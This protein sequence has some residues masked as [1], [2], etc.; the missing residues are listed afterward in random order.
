MPPILHERRG[1]IL[2]VALSAQCLHAALPLDQRPA[3]AD[4]WGYRPADGAAVALNPPSFAWIAP[5]DATRYQVQWSSDASFPAGSSTTVENVAWPAYTHH[6]AFRPGVWFWRYRAVTAKGVATEWSATR[7]F[8]VP[9]S[10]A[11][12]PMPTVAQQRERVPAGH[13][14]LFLRPE[15]LPRLRELAQGREAAAFAALRKA[16]EGYILKGPTPEPAHRGSAREKDNPELI[17]YWWPNREQTEAACTEAETLAFVYLLTGDKAYGEAA[18]RWVLH[19]ASWDPAGNTNFTLNCEA[20]KPML[21]R[22]ARAYDWA[23]DMFT[24][25]ERAKVR[26]A[27]RARVIDAWNSSEVG[28]GVGHLQRPFGSHANRVWH[29][30]AE[31]G[32]AFLD[33]IPEAPVWLDYAVTK[34]FT[35]YPVWSD[36]DGGWHEG[37]SYW[38]GYQNKAVW[39]LQVAQAALG[40][41]GMRK[42]FYAQVGDYP[43]YL[44][45]PNSPN[46]GFG[47]LSGRPITPPAFMEY[48]LRARGASGDGG[49]A[50]YWRDWAERGG[51]PANGGFLGF[52]YRAN[53]PPLPEKRPLAELPP[54]KVFHGVGVASLHLTLADSRDDVHLAFKSSP[55]GTQSHGHNSQNGFLLNAYGEALLVAN[56]YRDLHGSKFHYQYVH[57]TRAQNAVL[58][59]GEGQ[60][61]HSAAST[62]RIVREELS[63]S[64]DYVAGDATKAYGGRL[65]KAWRHVVFLKGDRPCVVLYDELVAP[66][67]A[68]YQFM[69]HAPR[70][71]TVDEAAARLK[72]EQPRAGLEIACLSPEPLTF[73]QTDGFQPPPTREFPNL[74]HVEAGTTA[75]RAEIG[76]VTVLVPHRAGQAGP[77][78]ARRV[79][80]DGEVKVELDLG[81]H[82]AVVRFPAPGRETPVRVER[83]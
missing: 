4:E 75:K 25:A 41:D 42:P 69:L 18:R 35:C 58:V 11:E 68:T 74:W 2:A 72:V 34:F 51:M 55:F 6:V 44:A 33:E 26:A 3:R 50:G 23:W 14:R 77:W 19:L 13:P 29:K 36:D 83:K 49:R 43:M 67:P 80:A 7:R 31:A 64:Y 32:I 28:R 62:G 1:L 24:D 21:Y 54:S 71:F 15:D 9:A 39:W 52:L 59:D 17:K 57:S 8:E 20:A 73:R 5:A 22:P 56:T 76:V 78:T 37:V 40:I 61:P 48:H 30:I 82:A 10:A 16:A 53:L 46:A 27:M 47:D 60:V 38:S 63:A 12:L 45:P 79:E 70:A 81:G 65:R 66:K